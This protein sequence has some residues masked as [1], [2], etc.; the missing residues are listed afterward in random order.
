MPGMTLAYTTERHPATMD[1]TMTFDRCMRITG[2]GWIETAMRSEHGTDQVLIS[3]NKKYENFTH[4]LLLDPSVC[5]MNQTA[6][7]YLPDGHHLDTAQRYRVL[8]IVVDVYENFPARFFLF[9]SYLLRSLQHVCLSPF[10]TWHGLNHCPWPVLAIYCL[11]HE[12]DCHGIQV[13][14]LGCSVAG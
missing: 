2:T 14:N 10:L 3:S 13:E 8:L 12:P 5:L 1:Y 4:V 7:G 11:R 6:P 9:D